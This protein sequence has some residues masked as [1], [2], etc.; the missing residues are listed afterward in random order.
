MCRALVQVLP[1]EAAAAALTPLCSRL[2]GTL[3][4]GQALTQPN[5]SAV[6]QILSS[7]GQLRPDIFAQHAVGFANFVLKTLLPCGMPLFTR[8]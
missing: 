6:I 3:A 1:R 2:M 8:F 7:I 4:Q 5:L